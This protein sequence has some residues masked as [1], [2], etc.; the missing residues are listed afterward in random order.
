MTLAWELFAFLLGEDKGLA[1]TRNVAS[2]STPVPVKK[3]T[4][5]KLYPSL[6]QV[7][8][9]AGTLKERHYA[10]SQKAAELQVQ[11]LSGGRRWLETYF[12][13]YLD[14][15]V[16]KIM[17]R[18]QADGTGRFDDSIRGST[19]DARLHSVVHKMPMIKKLQLW[20]KEVLMLHSPDAP[21]EVCFD[22]FFTL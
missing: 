12:R 8:S 22:L 14:D 19:T 15:H 13:R 10:G 16:V 11:F 3:A 17:E 20:S 4:S 5:S 1:T 7:E 6:D 9:Q 2:L 18:R 21:W